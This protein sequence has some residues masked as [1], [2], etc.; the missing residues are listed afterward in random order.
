MTVR[1]GETAFVPIR[2]PLNFLRLA[3]Q[4]A[5]RLYYPLRPFIYFFLT[6]G[7][8]RKHHFISFF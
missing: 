2:V 4:G 3:K 8:K 6:I 5:V 7:Q 1:V